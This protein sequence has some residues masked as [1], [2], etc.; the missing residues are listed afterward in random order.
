M[1]LPNR[2][3]TWIGKTIIV[4]MWIAGWIFCLSYLNPL[5]WPIVFL[6]AGIVTW[7]FLAREGKKSTQ[8]LRQIVES[9][10][11]EALPGLSDELKSRLTDL[12]LQND[13]LR[14][15]KFRNAYQ[16][17]TDK[18]TILIVNTYQLVRSDDD[19]PNA[20][21]KW[22]E[23]PQ[24]PL[25]IAIG[26]DAQIPA[27]AVYPRRTWN[28]WLELLLFALLEVP[29]R[30]RPGKLQALKQFAWGGLRI[31]AAHSFSRQNCIVADDP[32]AAQKY[33]TATK[34]AL[35]EQ[36]E[37]LIM[38]TRDNMLLIYFRYKKISDDTL[39]PMFDECLKRYE[40]LAE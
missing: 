20:T 7:W 15:V 8:Q 26:Q 2:R 16:A 31:D 19:G 14:E 13:Y 25:G 36:R 39:L 1:N 30:G 17:A 34:A 11:I 22:T 28:L 35:L 37:D 38:E 29:F 32:L 40:C 18:L 23:Y 27:M 12:H 24:F 9:L 5:L 33:L 6:I 4:L 21:P 10:Q 3:N